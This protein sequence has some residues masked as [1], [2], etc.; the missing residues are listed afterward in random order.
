[1]IPAGVTVNG[2]AKLSPDSPHRD[3]KLAKSRLTRTAEMPIRRGE[4]VCTNYDTGPYQI[5]DI[6]GP[7]CCPAYLDQIDMANP[8]PS[9]AH[10]HLTC[11]DASPEGKKRG[12][13]Y[14]NGYRLDGT[15]VWGDDELIFKGPDKQVTP[16]M[17][18]PS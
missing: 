18:G 12:F 10:Y 11:I 6:Q 15:N 17:F 7:C 16:D 1:M 2:T 4:V 14:L 8:P 3:W 13:S 9:E 5:V